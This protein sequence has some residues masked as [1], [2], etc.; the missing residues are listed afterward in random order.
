[1][2]FT[3]EEH[4]EMEGH[5]PFD[6]PDAVELPSG[7]HLA[8]AKARIHYLLK[9]T[10]IEG[11]RHRIGAE[12]GPPGWVPGYYLRR[13]WSGGNAGDRRARDLRELGV[14]IEIREFDS[15]S[16]GETRTFLYRW[17][18]DPAA[19]VRS[20][21]HAESSP[22]ARGGLMGRF[23]TESRSSGRPG[24]VEAPGSLRFWTSIGRPGAVEM[25][26]VN[27]F[28]AH[29]H[30]LAVPRTLFA[31]RVHGLERTE[32]LEEYRSELRARWVEGSLRRLVEAGGELVIWVTPEHAEAM[33][34]LPEIAAVL[35]RCGAASL[36][37][38]SRGAA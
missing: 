28:S 22:Q 29:G 13:A 36:G 24:S 26:T 1:M 25:A 32:A 2:T 37:E 14:G 10:A 8:G 34:V 12:I 11:I 6:L 27:P 33:N 19:A 30:P 17:T 35:V 31:R 3:R 15:P 18:H 21:S 38:L 7:R 23:P 5:A 20:A 16:R 9:R 4:L